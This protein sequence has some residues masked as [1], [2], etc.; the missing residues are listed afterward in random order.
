MNEKIEKIEKIDKLLF[1][2][3]SGFLGQNIIETIKRRFSVVTL[4]R[5]ATNDIKADLGD[6]LPPLP[7]R[8]DVVLHAASRVY[9]T[10]RTPEECDAFD[11]DIRLA[12]VNLCHALERVGVPRSFV[13]ISTVSVYGCTSATDIDETC[14]LNPKTPYGIAKVQAEEFLTDWAKRHGVTLSILRPAL[15]MGENLLGNLG[16]IEHAIARHRYMDIGGG[17]TLKSVV[18]AEDVARAVFLAEPRGGVYNLC[19]ESSPSVRDISHYLARR[20]GVSH[21]PTMPMWM[22]RCVAGFGDRFGFIPLN[23]SRLSKLT[24]TLT[25][26]SN[27]AVSA[28]GWHPVAFGKE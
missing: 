2:G 7:H 1:T 23:S 24:N 5:S 26:S 19:C 12:T 17:R 8:F 28:L 4:G 10:P 16:M 14:P 25:F 11:R 18:M 21:I 22:A 15:I 27:R 20:H 13:F 3:A 9:G 6:G